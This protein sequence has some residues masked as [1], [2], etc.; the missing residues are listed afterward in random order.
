MPSIDDVLRQAFDAPDQEWIR[1]A[2]SARDELMSQHRRQQ[3]QRR[4]VA[5]VLA[6]AAL[7]IAWTVL[8]GEPRAR[9]V[10]PTQPSPTS[11]TPAGATPLEGTWRS[12]PLDAS[13]V[14]AATRA[15]GAP[16]AAAS[17]LAQLP[18]AP[19]MVVVSIRGANLS[20][21]VQRA[22]GRRVVLDRESVAVEG[23]LVTVRP[24]DIT[25][26]TVHRWSI[27]SDAL[28]MEFGSTTEPVR[29]GVPGGAWQRLF[30]DSATFTR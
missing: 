20:T 17:M 11:S 28:T 13:D 12:A 8:D 6:A 23:D 26:R 19:F 16:Q 22:G 18:R 10:E 25:A 15:A 5:G 3:S 7:V 2:P 1:R 24:F 30:Y 21:Y 9:T 14:R 29:D 27:A 4:T